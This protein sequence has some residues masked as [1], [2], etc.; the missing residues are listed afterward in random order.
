MVLVI[1]L[2]A[3]F[4]SGSPTPTTG[5]GSAVRLA[6]TVPASVFNQVGLGSVE[7]GNSP[8]SRAPSGAPSL[9]GSDGRPEFLYMGALWCPYCAAER[10]VMLTAVS[11]FGTLSGVQLSTSSGSDV[12]P[13]TPT[14]SFHGSSWQSSY[15]DFVPVEYQDRDHNPLETPTAQQSS[16]EQ[17]V[18]S[19]GNIPFLYLDG[20]FTQSGASYSPQDL[21]GLS[22]GEIASRLH[23]DPS[24]TV[25][26]DILGNANLLSAAICGT[27]GGQPATVCQSPG[28]KA[29]EPALP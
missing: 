20:K 10:W 28:V 18:D 21:A 13:N 7:K 3:H 1:V 25:A 14:F 17:T 16:I 22:Q 2:V 29:A 5:N 27:T 12:Y 19:N 26:K 8:L 24:S 9:T 6:S 15:V 23:N 4:S 11:R